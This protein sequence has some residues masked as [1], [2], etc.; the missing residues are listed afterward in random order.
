MARL[1]SLGTFALGGIVTALSGQQPK[2]Y[3]QA[4]DLSDRPVQGVQFSVKD[5]ISAVS[6]RTDVAG[7]AEIPLTANVKP[8]ASVELSLIGTKYRLFSPW[9]RRVLVPLD[10]AAAVPVWLYEEG[11]KFQL[12]TLV[13]TTLRERVAQSTVSPVISTPND[14]KKQQ[15]A[16][17]ARIARECHITVEELERVITLLAS[18][19]PYELGLK[20]L[21]QGQY[22]EAASQ[23]AKALDRAVAERASP[24]KVMKAGL[25][26][27]HA[28]FLAGDYRQAAEAYRQAACT[29]GDDPGLLNGL[30]LALAKTAD[31][32]GAETQLRRVV[33]I[34][35]RESAPDS[36]DLAIAYTNLGYILQESQKCAEAEPYLVQALAIWRKTLLDA[37]ER[38]ATANGN[39]AKAK[40]CRGDYAG[41]A[42]YFQQELNVWERV[43]GPT[44]PY[45]EKLYQYSRNMYNGNQYS[46]AEPAFQR[47]LAIWEQKSPNRADVIRTL[48]YL[49]RIRLRAKDLAAAEKHFLR[50][51]AEQGG[52]TGVDSPPQ[53]G[54]LEELLDVYEAK[55]DAANLER[56]YIRILQIWRKA[57]PSESS[58]QN[59]AVVARNLA[60]LVFNQGEYARAKPL[61]EQALPLAEQSF[62]PGHPRI[63]E[64]R[65]ALDNIDRM[66]TADR[67]KPP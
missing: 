2:L 38:L 23:L 12:G 63:A 22:S 17:L 29:A 51:L 15:K 55:G 60:I 11:T 30:A 1:A 64:L 59:I 36:E 10:S 58:K 8:G 24:E 34:K 16:E 5:V 54:I 19:D 4:S 32:S 45:A 26:L 6:G 49:G 33:E 65:K 18:Q 31:L 66:S 43:M 20:A 7:N 61:L 44:P 9:N 57:P 52:A 14:P 47:A 62:P 50:A 56:C 27:G 39:V 48:G 35:K 21:Y 37:D 41:A 25:F 42:D 46:L 13:I 3:I 28:Q 53:V 40:Y 67:I